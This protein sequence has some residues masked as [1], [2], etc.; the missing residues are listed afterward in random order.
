MTPGLCW[1]I[2]FVNSTRCGVSLSPLHG[3]PVPPSMMIPHKYTNTLCVR[4]HSCATTHHGLLC[5]QCLHTQSPG[6]LFMI[7][8]T[9]HNSLLCWNFSPFKLSITCTWVSFVH[10]TNAS[11]TIYKSLVPTGMWRMCSWSS[12]TPARPRTGGRA[13]CCSRSACSGRQ[14]RPSQSLSLSICHT[15]RRVSCSLNGCYHA[16]QWLALLAWQSA[17]FRA[18]AWGA[19]R[20]SS[21]PCIG[22]AWP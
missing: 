12:K 20:P 10:P 3:V 4:L 11:S 2:R 9:T 16:W 22:H 8:N 7:K 21:P 6:P 17:K 18:S 15:S 14:M 19:I 5:P 13:G 1:C